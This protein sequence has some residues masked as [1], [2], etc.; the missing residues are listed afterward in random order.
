MKSIFCNAV[1][2][3]DFCF[4]S[5]HYNALLTESRLRLVRDGEWSWCPRLIPCLCGS[6]VTST[7]WRI[8][9]KSGTFALC[10]SEVTPP[11]PDA[12]I[13]R[14]VMAQQRTIARQSV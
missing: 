2:I 14:E 8:A 3:W 13:Y 5:H 12:R 9:F 6:F 11:R 1:I 4:L 10:W 7:A